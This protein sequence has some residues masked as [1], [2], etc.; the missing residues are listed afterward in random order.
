MIVYGATVLTPGSE[1]IAAW[2][3]NEDDGFFEPDCTVLD[4]VILDGSINTGKT[5]TIL[6]GP[7][8]SCAAIS[9]APQHAL[10]RT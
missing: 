9:E 3:A 6:S 4:L 2:K 5:F 10:I 1:T 8:A 7:L